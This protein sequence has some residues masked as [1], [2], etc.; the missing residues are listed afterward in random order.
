MTDLLD[1]VGFSQRQASFKFELL[2]QEL[3]GLGEFEVAAPNCKISN[4]INRTIKRTMSDLVIPPTTKKEINTLSD[5]V[6]PRMVLSDGTS[7]TLGVFVFSDTSQ[8]PLSPGVITRETTLTDQGITLDQPTARTYS[9]GPGTNLGVAIQS[10]LDG[11][12]AITDIEPSTRQV[13]GE[14]AMTWPSGTSRL[15]IIYDLCAAA[16]FYSLFFNNDGVARAMSVPDLAAEE[17]TLR[18]GTLPGEQKVFRETIIITDDL[19]EAPNRYIVISTGMNDVEIV[20]F[21]DVPSTSPNS[22]ENRGFVV[23]HVTNQQG[24]ESSAAA[25]EAAKAIGQSDFNTFSWV[26]F[27]AAP[28]PRHDTFDIVAWDN[29]NYREQNWDLTLRE[30]GPHRHE[31]RRIFNEP[32]N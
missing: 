27:D 19:L 10:M 16:G 15:A 20:G 30:G 32:V 3:N 24:L 11:L 18:Y 14:E 23:A 26:T 25:T 4:N 21:W 13:K 7:Y 29:V 22:K 5:R 8:R 28:D 17:A 31:L 1:L 9:F 2:D 6:R 12:V